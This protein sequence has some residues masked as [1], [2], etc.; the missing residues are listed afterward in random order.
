[1]KLF[2]HSRH[3][4]ED[5]GLRV[6]IEFPPSQWREI[7]EGVGKVLLTAHPAKFCDVSGEADPQR[8]KCKKSALYLT[9]QL[10]P[11]RTTVLVPQGRSSRQRQEVRR[12]TYKR[13]RVA[14]ANPAARG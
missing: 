5:R 6:F 1:M 3:V 12:Q 14:R 7:A 11:E 9:S 2:A 8:H 4:Y 10:Q 13:S